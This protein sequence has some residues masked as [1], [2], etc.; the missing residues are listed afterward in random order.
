M[1]EGHSANVAEREHEGDSTQ[2][3]PALVRVTCRGRSVAD[4]AR[5]RQ[6]MAPGDALEEEL[7][8]RVLTTARPA[9]SALGAAALDALALSLGGCVTIDFNAGV[10]LPSL[11]MLGSGRRS[12]GLVA[13]ACSI[14]WAAP[15]T[16]PSPRQRP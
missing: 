13:N 15:R 6:G 12:T 5:R 14:A 8:E 16:S 10:G 3:K 9:Y 1:C 2:A 11:A 4:A 7:P